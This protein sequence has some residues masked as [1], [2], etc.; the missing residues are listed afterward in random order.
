MIGAPGAILHTVTPEAVAP[1]PDVADRGRGEVHRAAQRVGVAVA[2]EEAPA[3][4]D[5]LVALGVDPHHPL[6]AGRLGRRG[7]PNAGETPPCA[8][9]PRA[10]SEMSGRVS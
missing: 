3:G 1:A 10:D 6:G 8:A 7:G 2:L 5:G 4:G 9:A